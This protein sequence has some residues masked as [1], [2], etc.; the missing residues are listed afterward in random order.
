MLPLAEQ[1]IATPDESV[2][3]SDGTAPVPDQQEIARRLV[4]GFLHSV[5]NTS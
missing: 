3:P 1:R 5:T 2:L 4:A